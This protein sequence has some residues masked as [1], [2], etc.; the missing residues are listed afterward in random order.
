MA[1]ASL[2]LGLF[3]KNI[4]SLSCPDQREPR[5]WT[6]RPEKVLVSVWHSQLAEL[7][8]LCLYRRSI[9]PSKGGYFSS[10][11]TETL[12]PLWLCRFKMTTE[13]HD[14]GFCF[15]ACYERCSLR[16]ASVCDPELSLATP[17]ISTWLAGKRCGYD[18]RSVRRDELCLVWWIA[19]CASNHKRCFSGSVQS[20]K[21]W[22]R[23]TK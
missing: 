16:A 5:V 23:E 2:D 1:V 11:A 14:D 20:Q 22:E 10:S 12:T 3:L 15:D 13:Q 9:D 7:Q 8:S 21:R 17:T 18:H 4:Y 6:R 19:E